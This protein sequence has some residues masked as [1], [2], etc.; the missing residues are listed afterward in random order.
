MKVSAVTAEDIFFS[1][2]RRYVTGEVTEP[3]CLATE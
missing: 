1:K 2:Q 3:E